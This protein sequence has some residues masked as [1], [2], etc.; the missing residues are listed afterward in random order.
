MET[1]SNLTFKGKITTIQERKELLLIKNF[2]L[3]VKKENKD[4][5]PKKWGKLQG[6]KQKNG[7]FDPEFST[8]LPLYDAFRTVNWE[9]IRIEI[10]SLSFV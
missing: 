10:G 8:M 6:E 1:T 2:L 9:K 5:E 3:G 7:A 4:F